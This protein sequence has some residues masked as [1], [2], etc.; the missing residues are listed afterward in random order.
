MDI[1][2]RVFD[3]DR[4]EYLK[5]SLHELLNG[6]GDDCADCDAQRFRHLVLFDDVG[7]DII[8]KH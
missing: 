4:N 6:I 2:F 3:G 8:I 7:V 1:S 5:Q